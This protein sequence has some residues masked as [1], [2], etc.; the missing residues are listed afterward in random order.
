VAVLKVSTGG[1]Q[2]KIVLIV[3][4]AL[5]AVFGTLDFAA[6][7]YG[8][9]ILLYFLSAVLFTIVILEEKTNDNA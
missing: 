6:G 2:M 3:I 5:D 4:S 7:R 1:I 9:G 8:T